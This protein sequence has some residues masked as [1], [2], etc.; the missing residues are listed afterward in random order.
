MS[1]NF[2]TG[3]LSKRD[4]YFKFT[5]KNHQFEA[6]VTKVKRS[7]FRQPRWNIQRYFS[8]I[9]CKKLCSKLNFFHLFD[10]FLSFLWKCYD[11]TIANQT[12]C[13]RFD[14]LSTFLQKKLD[15]RAFF[16]IPRQILDIFT[17]SKSEESPCSVMADMI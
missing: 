17:G 3:I 11:K 2:D 14:N 1:R 4:H 13:L 9:K 15:N 5:S 16:K 6:S 7:H 8:S 12:F 10:G